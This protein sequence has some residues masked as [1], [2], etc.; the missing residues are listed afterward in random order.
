MSFTAAYR[1]SLEDG[2]LLKKVEMARRHYEAC[3]LCPHECGVDRRRERGI[4]RG[5]P[6]T[7]VASYGPHFGEE[8][9]L[10][11]YRGSGTI[12]FAHCNLGCV[13]CQ[14]YTISIHGRGTSISNEELASIMLLLQDHYRCHNINLVT[15]THFVP[16]IL[17]AVYLAAQK[18]LR[19]PIVYNCSGYENVETLKILDGV[20]DIYMPD[21]KYN[22]PELAGRYSRT[23]DYPEK[24]KLA[25]KEMNRQVGDLRVDEKG[26]AYRGLLIRHLVLPGGMEDT[27]EILGF[28]GEE[29]SPDCLVNVMG[30]YYPAHRASEYQEIARRLTPKEFREAVDYARE[31]GLRLA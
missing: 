28:I 18:G 2:S 30:Q 10:V 9:V 31:L 6:K 19:L 13:Y 24:A 3:F 7:V 15:P 4:C 12:F 27:K 20:I 25:L 11:G 16:N 29:L 14:N 23:R 22:S 26:I 5:G 21:F 17:E 8:D 1:K